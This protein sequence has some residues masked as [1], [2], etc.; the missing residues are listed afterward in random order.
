MNRP[1]N[2]LGFIARTELEKAAFSNGYRLDLG[3]EHGWLHRA[4]TTA[5]GDLW[6][7]AASEKG[8][9]L[10]SVARPEVAAELD[11]PRSL[12]LSG[13]GAVSFAFPSL[14]E[15]YSSLDRVYHLCISLPTAPL[16]AFENATSALPKSTEAEQLI[17]RRVGQDLFRQALMNY[18]KGR[19]PLTGIADPALLRASHIVAWADCDSDAQ[20]LDVHNGLLLSALWD[21]AFDAGLVSFADDGSVLHSPHLSAAAAA[22]LRLDAITPLIPLTDE[23]R[24]NLVRHRARHRF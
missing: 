18:W 5:R 21:A 4:S 17:V 19:C 10:L 22:E 16:E 12:G 11:A 24:K 8:P 14:N 3:T 6:L 1:E 23:H 2:P 9:W 20:R 7:G 15:L 13:P